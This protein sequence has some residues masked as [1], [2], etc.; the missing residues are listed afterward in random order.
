M[1]KISERA[2]PGTRTRPATAANRA[3]P[4]PALQRYKSILLAERLGGLKSPKLNTSGYSPDSQ[5]YVPSN[6]IAPFAVKPEFNAE[7]LPG[8]KN[9]PQIR[10]RT[11]PEHIEQEPGGTFRH[12]SPALPDDCTQNETGYITPTGRA[13]PHGSISDPNAFFARVRTR[14]S[15]ESSTQSSAGTRVKT[16]DP[17]VRTKPNNS[18]ITRLGSAVTGK[19]I[20]AAAAILQNSFN[21][22]DEKKQ[23]PLTSE[24]LS[25]AIG[26]ALFRA[27]T[28]TTRKLFRITKGVLGTS[29][30]STAAPR[31]ITPHA[32]NTTRKT[33]PNKPPYTP[34]QKF[35]L[36]AAKN[37]P[38]QAERL[39]VR[40]RPN[41]TEIN[42]RV[43]N[44]HVFVRTKD[45][46]AAPKADAAPGHT[47]TRAGSD[48]TQTRG[49]AK[50]EKSSQN[51][52][53]PKALA[54][55][56]TV[57][58]VQ[59][60]IKAVGGAVSGEDND[61]TKL[62]S[63]PFKALANKALQYILPAIAGFIVQLL[64]PF[65]LFMAIMSS[66]FGALFSGESVSADTVSISSVFAECDYDASDIVN[67]RV[68][69]LTAEQRTLHGDAA[70]INVKLTGEFA[71]P[72]EILAVW[73]VKT[74]ASGTNPTDV[75]SI[76]RAKADSLRAVYWD[77]NYI[78]YTVTS[79][80]RRTSDTEQT[81]VLITISRNRLTLNEITDLY[82]FSDEQNAILD[83]LLSDYY[84]MLKE[85]VNSLELSSVQAREV[86]DNLP[87]GLA[88]ER[89][90]V[91]ENALTLVG[92]VN[93]FWGGKS[94]A[95]GWDSRWGSIREVTADGSDSTGSYRPYGLDCSGF[96]G[97]AYINGFNDAAVFYNLG[98]T[99]REQHNKSTG[100]SFYDAQPGDLAFFA[101]LS[102]VGIIVGWNADRSDL[103]V[104]HCASG[105]D[106]VVITEFTA[107][108]FHSIGT[109]NNVF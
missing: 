53:G 8:S 80:T 71:D 5:G 95:L 84:D 6:F 52:N 9:N 51:Q 89:R 4:N 2:A 91:V 79:H 59:G 31:N 58:K 38:P 55:A 37:T 12:E 82:G 87:P 50:K 93:Y 97:W 36:S 54:I 86:L 94:F 35:M 47:K 49:S 39:Y 11:R 45:N 17:H 26:A 16:S 14:E 64:P 66:P 65:M 7:S 69:D 25:K 85:L 105:R 22:E 88:P 44:Q 56:R 102:H 107:T 13:V 108:G 3:T 21:D 78:D 15:H 24:D 19:A 10:V 62:L 60:A 98:Y 46:S 75:A 34:P 43:K 1:H 18:T 33:V 92:K 32:A 28:D 101:D 104:V 90:A 23:N 81:D 20:F 30:P 109:P 83:E 70:E 99:A 42:V 67:A 27:S 96:T 74:A 63:L 77:F 57:M 68:S 106:N 41:Q 48:R 103:L 100:V 61:I 40:T 73:A 72:I 76:D 29:A